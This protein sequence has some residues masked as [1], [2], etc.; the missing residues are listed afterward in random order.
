MF[1]IVIGNLTQ[2]ELI[3]VLGRLV[4]QIGKDVE[5]GKFNDEG[6]IEAGDIIDLAQGFIA[7]ALKEYSDTE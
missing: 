2:G 7:D 1:G 4:E 3:Q 6:G 5:S